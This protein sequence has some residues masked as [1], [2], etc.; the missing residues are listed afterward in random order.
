VP[1]VGDFA[2][3]KA[4]R[5]V[6]QYLKDHEATVSA[7]YISNVE[8]YLTPAPKLAN[9]YGNVGTLPLTPA[10]TFIRSAQVPGNQPGL[11]QSSLGSMQTALDAVLEGR[12]TNWNDIL[13]LT[14][15]P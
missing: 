11:A 15:T 6:G 14:H 5:T 13:K 9:F 1:L 3:P 7:F 10:S 12:A 8:Q 4:I 2:G